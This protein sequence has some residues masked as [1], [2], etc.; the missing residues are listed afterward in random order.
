MIK[1]LKH[2]NFQHNCLCKNFIFYYLIFMNHTL[3]SNFSWLHNCLWETNWSLHEYIYIFYKLTSFVRILVAWSEEQRSLCHV[4]LYPTR[5]LSECKHYDYDYNW[6]DK[7]LKGNNFKIAFASFASFSG[8][9]LNDE[10]HHH[11]SRK[12]R[13]NSVNFRNHSNVFWITIKTGR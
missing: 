1:L 6:Q 10:D 11:Q 2:N 8:C 12:T 5:F 4:H 9:M 13:K 7:T 3:R